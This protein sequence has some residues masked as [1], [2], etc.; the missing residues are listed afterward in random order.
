[1]RM[2]PR[3]GLMVTTCSGLLCNLSTLPSRGSVPTAS[4]SGQRLVGH[5]RGLLKSVLPGKTEGLC[6]LKILKDMALLCS[7]GPSTHPQQLYLRRQPS[8]LP[9]PALFPFG[10]GKPCTSRYSQSPLPEHRLKL[11][12]TSFFLCVVVPHGV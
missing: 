4:D 7:A 10:R 8:C 6:S 1:M 3:E 12:L 11:G 2:R 5:P 9:A